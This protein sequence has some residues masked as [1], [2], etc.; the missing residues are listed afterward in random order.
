M[1]DRKTQLKKLERW[2]L[3]A[4]LWRFLYMVTLV[5]GKAMAFFL[6]TG[7]A[8]WVIDRI[9]PLP[10]AGRISL[11]ILTLLGTGAGAVV[12]TKAWRGWTKMGIAQMLGGFFAPSDALLN[13]WELAHRL[14][15]EAESAEL[16][17]KSLEQVG[18]QL[19]ERPLGTMVRPRRW[20]SWVSLSAGMVI[21]GA[22]LFPRV[23]ESV[24]ASF[25]RVYYPFGTDQVHGLASVA[26]GNAW[27]PAG[28]N[29]VISVALSKPG[30]AAPELWVR[31]DGTGWDRRALTNPKAGEYRYVFHNL[32]EAVS[33]KVRY[34]R[35][36]TSTFRL[37]PYRPP[38]FAGLRVELIYPTYTGKPRQ[39]LENSLSWRALKG[40]EVRV[41][42]RLDQD[43]SGV[44]ARFQDGKALEAVLKGGRD[45]SLAFEAFESGEIRLRTLGAGS[46]GRIAGEI[47]LRMD[48]MEDGGPQIKILAPAQDLMVSPHDRLPISYEVEDDFGVAEV[49]LNAQVEGKPVQKTLLKSF[50]RSAGAGERGMV[51]QGVFE[52]VWSLESLKL[53]P[54][55][56]VRYSLLA[57]DVNSLTGPGE[58]QSAAFLL[59]VASYERD[60]ELLEKSLADFRKN[61]LDILSEESLLQEKLKTPSADWPDAARRVPGLSDWPSLLHGQRNASRRIREQSA[62]L[63]SLVKRMERDPHTDQV[64]AAEH[65]SILNNLRALEEDALP[66]AETA[67][68]QRQAEPAARAVDEVVSELERLSLLSEDVLQ[69]ENMRDLLSR[70]NELTESARFLS[71]ALSE[72]PGQPLSP[73]DQRRMR[74]VLDEMSAL[75]RQIMD[76]IQKMPQELPE[77]FVNQE[78]VKTL[79]MDQVQ[80]LMTEMQKALAR[81]DAAGALAAAKRMLEQLQEM[82]SILQKAGEDLPGGPS[83]YGEGLA[84]E[85]TQSQNQLRL[86]IER[87]ETLKNKTHKFAETAFSRL[88]EEERSALK[89]LAQEHG[90]LGADL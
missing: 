88:V 17:D 63:E 23:P 21:V 6:G 39:V 54:G 52:T 42:G 19:A 25:L 85:M 82:K 31:S 55:D 45:V 75:M 27:V 3:K 36:W 69:A 41:R 79:R 59:E 86:I 56:R 22:L 12:L 47:A 81:G 78:S 64:A 4:R 33:Y 7:T 53:S 35:Q 14:E 51:R 72:R 20:R 73:E 66:R 9:V 67:L 26:P 2:F 80:S 13:N 84:A 87:Q 10:R 89:E 65:Q 11:W 29:V 28:D 1:N 46:S 34:K 8:W 49:F 58:S 38:K 57:R 68:S 32:V 16:I 18:A 15:G 30:P 70:Q 71:D 61:L 62:S 90:R 24:R 37:T 83:W 74:Q 77:D 5:W 76:Q 43:V 40:C 44:S 50:P 60:H 48:V